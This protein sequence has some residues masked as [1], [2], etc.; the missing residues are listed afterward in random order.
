MCQQKRTALS[1]SPFSLSPI[2]YIEWK[3][4]P[5]LALGKTVLPEKFSLYRKKLPQNTC[6]NSKIW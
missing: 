2:P 4:P 5:P 1:G 6:Q 3:Y